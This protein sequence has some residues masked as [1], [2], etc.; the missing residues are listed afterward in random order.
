MNFI[1]K[2]FFDNLL[3]ENN[4]D[5]YNINFI[6]NLRSKLKVLNDFFITLSQKRESYS[7]FK[8]CLDGIYIF[9]S[10]FLEK[11][12]QLMTSFKQLGIKLREIK[13]FLSKYK[14]LSKK[15]MLNK[16]YITEADIEK[17]LKNLN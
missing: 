13:T 6:L 15:L 10:F 1:P 17:N 11:N 4:V 3:N 5:K 16:P 14:N 9:F 7:K 8:N 2:I 12:I